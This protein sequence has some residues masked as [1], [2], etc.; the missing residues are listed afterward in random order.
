MGP[1]WTEVQRGG[2]ELCSEPRDLAVHLALLLQSRCT[3]CSIS[4]T[5]YFAL[6]TSLCSIT[7]STP[8]ESG[9]IG[10]FLPRQLRAPKGNLCRIGGQSPLEEQG[11]TTWES[12]SK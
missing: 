2:W 6:G 12:L 5:Q 11:L 9:R 4:T 10:G 3:L 8:A 1:C 7:S